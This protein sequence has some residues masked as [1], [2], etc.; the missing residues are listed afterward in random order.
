L[1]AGAGRLES[2]DDV[3]IQP[4]RDRDFAVGFLRP[5]RVPDD[6]GDRLGQVW[7]GVGSASMPRAIL[8]SS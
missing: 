3:A 6:T 1:R 5:A 4:S 2:L 7:R 8:A